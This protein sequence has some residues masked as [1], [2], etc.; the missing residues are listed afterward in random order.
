[1]LKIGICDDKK[2]IVKALKEILEECMEEEGIQGKITEFYSGQELLT[3]YSGEEAVFLD[4]D[5]PGMDGIETGRNIRK[6]GYDCKI[7]MATGVEARFKEAF[8]IEALRFISKPFQKREIKEALEA[9]LKTRIGTEGIELYSGRSLYFFPQKKI[10]YII[11]V[12]SAAEF[13]LEEGVFRKETSLAE[14]E[15]VLDRRLFYRVSKQCI[16]NM[17][18]IIAYKSGKILLRDCEIKVSVRKKK[19]FEKAYMEYRINY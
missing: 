8:Q 13:M 9:V 7:I 11:A 16:V 15:N 4:I 1:M 18:K 6:R 2:M 14:L 19:E 12:N 17:E 3:G 10:Q 5:M